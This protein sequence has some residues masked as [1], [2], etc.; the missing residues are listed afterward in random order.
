MSLFLEITPVYAAAI[1]Q[2]LAIVFFPIVIL[3]PAHIFICSAVKLEKETSG[4]QNDYWI[5]VAHWPWFRTQDI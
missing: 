1:N 2:R 5:D 4:M 3:I